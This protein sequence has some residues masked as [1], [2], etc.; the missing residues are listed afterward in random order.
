MQEILREGVSNTSSS[1]VLPVSL[2]AW[3]A[4]VWGIVFVCQFFWLAFALTG[5]CRQT[6][7][8]PVYNNPKLLPVQVHIFF[9][10]AVLTQVSMSQYSLRQILHIFGY[11]TSHSC[12]REMMSDILLLC[13]ISVNVLV[14]L[15]AD[16]GI[17]IIVPEYVHL[18]IY[19]SIHTYKCDFHLYIAYWQVSWPIT[20]NKQLLWT[21][22]KASLP[23]VLVITSVQTVRRESVKQLNTIPLNPFN[24]GKVWQHQCTEIRAVKS[25]LCRLHFEFV[26]QYTCTCV[27]TCVI[28][29]LNGK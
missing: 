27:F 21:M 22:V 28:W 9:S 16:C 26:H 1:Y 2:S 5:I 10:L 15:Y 24:Q 23:A 3:S 12:Q 14:W 13:L 8:G 20:V 4:S 18:S 25:S 11:L 17:K 29:L 7:L 19:L 6:V